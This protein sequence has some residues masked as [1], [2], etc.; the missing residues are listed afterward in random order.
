VARDRDGS[1]A[2]FA[3]NFGEKSASGT[4]TVESLPRGWTLIPDRWQITLDPMEQKLLSIRVEMDSP[5][6][7]IL[8]DDW[9]KLRGDFAD[10]GQPAL[11]FRL[12]A[13]WPTRDFTL[14]EP[15]AMKSG[16]VW[17]MSNSCRVCSAYLQVYSPMNDPSGAIMKSLVS[18]M[19][20]IQP[21]SSIDPMTVRLPPF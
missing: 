11:A 10:A 6:K 4:I 5:N 16:L 14:R 13:K 20:A 2:V 9:I 1:L 17:A 7:D 8:P 21:P 12:I 3:Y 18:G 15:P 19:K